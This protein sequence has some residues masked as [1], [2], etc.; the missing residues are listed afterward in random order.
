LAV[1]PTPTSV[2]PT[3]TATATPTATPAVVGITPP[4]QAPTPMP[5]LLDGSP[6]SLCRIQNVD[7]SAKCK[8]EGAGKAS[9]YSVVLKFE[10]ANLIAGETMQTMLSCSSEGARIK[11][12]L[13]NSNA[14]GEV[15]AT[16]APFAGGFAYFA[17]GEPPPN[18]ES[19]CIVRVSSNVRPG[20]CELALAIKACELGCSSTDWLST[21]LAIDSGV[22][23]QFAQ[24]KAQAK[25]LVKLRKN[26]SKEAQSY[27]A[28]GQK[29]FE[30]GWTAT[31]QFP[32]VTQSCSNARLCSAVSM[33]SGKKPM[34]AASLEL[35]DITLKIHA[36]VLKFSAKAQRKKLSQQKPRMQKL[37]IETV[38]KIETLAETRSACEQP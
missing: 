30:L 9:I 20:S 28:L 23:A 14:A 32:R 8:A 35:R 17:M 34:L 22:T 12:S 15:D 4:I 5:P 3:P 2:P 19:S 7:G 21:Q 24:I 38:K 6:N 10:R 29:A 37:Y 11:A 13:R 36:R 25:A 18:G 31:Y 33:Q 26:L 1:L 27:V 16:K